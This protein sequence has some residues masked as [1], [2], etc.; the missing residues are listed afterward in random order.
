[1]IKASVYIRSF[2]AKQRK[3]L[4]S[5]GE[6]EKLKTVPKILF[7]AL[8]KYFDQQKEIARLNRIIAYKQKKIEKLQETDNE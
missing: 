7:F 5:V 1:M 2:T 3:Q 4:E 6:L 8:D